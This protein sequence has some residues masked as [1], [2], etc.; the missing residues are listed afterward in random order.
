MLIGSACLFRTIWYG[1]NSNLWKGRRMSPLVYWDMMQVTG[2][3]L[4]LTYQTVMSKNIKERISTCLAISMED[5]KKKAY[6]LTRKEK[7]SATS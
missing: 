1:N 5:E 6:L 7:Q 2:R 4:L 3:D